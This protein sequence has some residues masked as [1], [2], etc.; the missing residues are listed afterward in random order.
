MTKILW[1]DDEIEHLRAH[2]LFLQE[3]GFHVTTVS[4]GID[5]IDELDQDFF[6]VVFLDE[7]M[8][9][10]TGLETLVKIKEKRPDLPVIM[11]TKSEE[12]L[13]MEDAIG[14]KIADYLIKPVNPNQI[15][16]TLKKN[17]DS[18]RLLGDRAMTSYRSQFMDLSSQIS[19]AHDFD[20]WLEVYNKLVFWDI[21]LSQTADPGM[22]GMLQAQQTEANGQFF[23]FISRNYLHWLKPNSDQEAPV[24]SHTAFKKLIYPVAKEEESLFVVLID[25]LRMDQWRTIRNILSDYFVIKQENAY[26]TILPTATQYARNSFFAGLMPSEIEKIHKDLWLN[27]NDEGSKNQYEPELLSLQLKRL[28][29]TRKHSYQKITTLDAGK[30]LVENFSN[31]NQNALNIVVYNFV[32]MLSHARTDMEVIKELAEDETAYRSL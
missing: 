9:G 25:N 20:S 21:E 3:K 26:C 12:E 2:I 18:K 6:D 13:I 8:P 28:G 1:A 29:Y 15:L 22:K 4:N 16:L 19:D 32:D 23:K 27:E 24:L 10:L 11:I 31:L 7:N 14:S 17:L 5:A 30:K